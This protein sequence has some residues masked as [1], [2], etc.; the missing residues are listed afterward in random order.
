MRVL[1]ILG[2]N[3]VSREKGHS[4]GQVLFTVIGDKTCKL[5]AHT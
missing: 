5:W 4:D 2:S 3:T 1:S